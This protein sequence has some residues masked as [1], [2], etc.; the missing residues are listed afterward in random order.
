LGRGPDDVALLTIIRAWP[1]PTARGPRAT[2]RTCHIDRHSS[3]RRRAPMT[4]EHSPQ[5]R[6]ASRRGSSADQSTWCAHSDLAAATFRHFSPGL[7]ND[8]TNRGQELSTPRRR[9][10]RRRCSYFLIPQV[11]GHSSGLTSERRWMKLSNVIFLWLSVAPAGILENDLETPNYRGSWIQYERTAISAEA[12]KVRTRRRN[13]STRKGEAGRF[14]NQS[15]RRAPHHRFVS[16]A[17][18][19]KSVNDI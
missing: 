12:P 14:G 8:L 19:H 2:W 4:I 6:R 9:A 13:R 15:C 18:R 5:L 10:A 1:L 17:R 16:Q 11:A 7:R 3:A